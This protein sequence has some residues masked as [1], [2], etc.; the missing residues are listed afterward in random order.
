[1]R[2]KVCSAI[3]NGFESGALDTIRVKKTRESMLKIAQ[4]LMDKDESVVSILN[5]LQAP[6][7]LFGPRKNTYLTRDDF[8]ATFNELSPKGRGFPRLMMGPDFGRS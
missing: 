8:R 5:R 2:I 1:M 4:E 3:R 6:D 7:S